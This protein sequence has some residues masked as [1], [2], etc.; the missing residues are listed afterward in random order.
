MGQT[1]CNRGTIGCTL[2]RRD[3]KRQGESAGEADEGAKAT[4]SKRTDFG[5]R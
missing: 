5:R 4:G 1:Y 3:K 2:L